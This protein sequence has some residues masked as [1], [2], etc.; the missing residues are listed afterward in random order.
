VRLERQRN[1]DARSRSREPSSTLFVRIAAS[2]EG[3]GKSR[4]YQRGARAL[5]ELRLHINPRGDVP[6]ALRLY[7]ALQHAAD[8]MIVRVRSQG[9]VRHERVH[10]FPVASTD[11]E[12]TSWSNPIEDFRRLLHFPLANLYL[13]IPMSGTPAEWD[14]L[15]V[16]LALNAHWPAGLAVADESFVLNAMPVE[17]SV[18][19]L[20]LP[21]VYDG[22]RTR[23][24]IE[25]P[26]PDA[27][28]QLREVLG[29][30]LLDPKNPGVRQPLLPGS[31]VPWA[32][33]KDGDVATSSGYALDVD[34]RGDQRAAYLEID[35][36]LGV[37]S[38]PR[39][40]HVDAEWYQPLGPPLDA[41]SAV[42]SIEDHDP[43]PVAWQLL[44]PVSLPADSPVLANSKGLNALLELHGKNTFD[45]GDLKQLLVG[46]GSKGSEVFSRVPQYFRGVRRVT[47]PDSESIQGSL[48]VY[49]IT[50]AEPPPAVRP[51]LE[52]LGSALPALLATWTGHSDIRVSIAFDERPEVEPLVFEVRNR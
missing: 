1:E 6:S 9:E 52:L 18:R 5:D 31:L 4:Y 21:I 16:E 39:T 12:R 28:Y 19:G 37:L 7:S 10:T 15:D 47:V 40:I 20:A 26:E 44:A 51:A 23:W 34:G 41:S 30:Y 3:R 13:P 25:H 14:F 27:G 29:V 11:P 49:D 46:L 32:D 35:G 24:L 8:K 17:N 36:D 48:V 45:L 2:K 22:T 50:C 38:E 43:G 42:V 33:A